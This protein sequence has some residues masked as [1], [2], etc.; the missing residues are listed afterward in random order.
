[1][2]PHPVQHITEKDVWLRDEVRR[3][4]KKEVKERIED[5]GL[6]VESIEWWTFLNEKEHDTA[7]LRS[8]GCIDQDNIHLEVRVN[9]VGCRCAA[10]WTS[11]ACG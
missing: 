10:G 7:D 4:V 9:Q 6:G 11:G 5:V 3:D 2:T 8:K 1:M